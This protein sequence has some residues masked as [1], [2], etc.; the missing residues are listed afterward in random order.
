RAA[1]GHLEGKIVLS[2]MDSSAG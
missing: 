1:Q 2:V